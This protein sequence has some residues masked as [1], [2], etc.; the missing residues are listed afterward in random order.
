MG[1]QEHASTYTHM[2]LISGIILFSLAQTDVSHMSRQD[3][4]D[5]DDKGLFLQAE[6]NLRN[7]ILLTWFTQVAAGTTFFNKSL[8]LTDYIIRLTKDLLT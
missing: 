3:D 2:A 6:W 5:E 7:F 4:D 8:N 1:L